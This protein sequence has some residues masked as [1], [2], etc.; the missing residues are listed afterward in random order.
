MLVDELE[1]E[2]IFLDFTHFYIKVLGS[3]RY[4]GFYSSKEL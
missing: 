1:M 2:K 3:H 4:G